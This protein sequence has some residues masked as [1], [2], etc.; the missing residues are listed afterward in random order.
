MY[1]AGSGLS[2]SRGAGGCCSVLS[3]SEGWSRLNGLVEAYTP[4]RH[5]RG[6]LSLIGMPMTSNDRVKLCEYI[7]CIIHTNKLVI[8]KEGRWS[9]E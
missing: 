8:A 1:M 9:I 2:S 6:G 3:W 7:E 4:V 5:S